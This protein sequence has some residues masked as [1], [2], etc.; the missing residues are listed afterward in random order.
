MPAE[1]KFNNLGIPYLVEFA[2]ISIR[3]SSL[4]SKKNK[5]GKKGAAKKEIKKDDK[6]KKLPPPPIRC[7]TCGHL[8][9]HSPRG[10]DDDEHGAR[11][12]GLHIRFASAS[13]STLQLTPGAPSQKLSDRRL[14]KLRWA[15]A[16]AVTRAGMTTPANE[17]GNPA[18]SASSA[19]SSSDGHSSARSTA[20][21]ASKQSLFK[22]TYGQVK[23]ALK[24]AGLVATPCPETGFENATRLGALFV[25]NSKTTGDGL[26]LTKLTLWG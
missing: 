19:G 3:S 8:P 5:D 17:D 24:N 26:Q 7:P 18:D 21:T 23:E 15:I 22:G 9:S 12:G 11:P 14:A 13:G 16:T 4:F 25:A 6:K 10:D 1:I 2:N 20:S